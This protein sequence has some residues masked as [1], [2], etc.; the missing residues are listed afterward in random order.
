M[1]AVLLLLL[2]VLPPTE[3]RQFHK[4]PLAQLA[5]TH[6]SH[7]E[8]CGLV[9]LSKK[10]ADGDIHVRLSEGSAFVVAEIVPYHRLPQPKKGQ[11]I[12]VDGISRQDRD[13]GWFE[14]H[15]VEAWHTR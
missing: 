13:H 6:W 12:C 9:T 8:V 3:D 7:V 1:I 5:K 10:E 15:P 14:V 4:V 11:R 2:A